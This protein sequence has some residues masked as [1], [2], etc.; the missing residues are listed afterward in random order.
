[1]LKEGQSRMLI[2]GIDQHH[3]GCLSIHDPS[4]LDP[5]VCV[6]LMYNQG[7]DAVHSLGEGSTYF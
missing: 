4:G 6:N 5:A 3:C 1:M 7:F 2:E